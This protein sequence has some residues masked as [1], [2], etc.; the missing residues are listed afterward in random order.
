MKKGRVIP[1]RPFTN[2]QIQIDYYLNLA[3]KNNKFLFK[4][5]NIFDENFQK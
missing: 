1:T 2:Q 5:P 4:Y 3:L